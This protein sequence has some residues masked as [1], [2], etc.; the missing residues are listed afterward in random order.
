[1]GK[2]VLTPLYTDEEFPYGRV[3]PDPSG[4]FG[5][6]SDD[7]P[8]CARCGLRHA[9]EM[10][11]H[12]HEQ[13]AVSAADAEAR[14]VHERLHDATRPFWYPPSLARGPV[15]PA[16]AGAVEEGVGSRFV[17]RTSQAA[18]HLADQ[19]LRPLVALIHEQLPG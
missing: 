8:V 5:E 13:H 19:Y 6:V 7:A 14:R 9:D 12:L 17:D 10:Q 15:H 1:M 16:Q 18:E 3:S 2:R 4:L 11:R